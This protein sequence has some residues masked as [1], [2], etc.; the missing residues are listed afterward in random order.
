MELRRVRFDDDLV[1]PLLAG[2]TIEYSTRYGDAD[3]LAH[4]HVEEF[5]PP[6]GE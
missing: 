5:D 1:G 2:L 4:A 3:E 6:T